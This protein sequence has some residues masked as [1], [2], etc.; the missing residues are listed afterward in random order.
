MSAR[1]HLP[2]LA[3]D[4]DHV[5]FASYGNDSI[6]L[7][8]WLHEHGKKQ[9]AVAYSDTGW[10][11]ADWPLRVTQ[12]E[13]WVRSLGFIPVRL[14]SEGMLGLVDRKHA[15][16]R[17]G[18]GKYQFCTEALKEAPAQKWLDIV[19]PDRNAI[20]YVGIRRDES[21]NRASFPEWTEES[22]NHG[23]RSLHAPLVRHDTAMRD[24]L[25]A[26]TPFA[27]LPYRSKECYP[28]VNARKHEIAAL[29]D[30]KVSVIRE[31]EAQMGINSKGNA[32]VMFS[33]KRHKGAVGIDAVITWSRTDR[34]GEPVTPSCDG[35]WCGS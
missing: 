14:T 31:K 32:I 2:G 20:C 17:G 7:I 15:W 25:L 22:A 19:D 1:D 27:P 9:V 12:A 28:C 13:S 33:L 4:V 16:P 35:G 23:G 21:A 34:S 6:A 26:R 3:H 10:A 18:G 30:D 8:Q 11:R 29:P 24:A 5:V